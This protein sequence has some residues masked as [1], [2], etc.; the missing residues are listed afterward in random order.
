MFICRN[1]DARNM[2]GVVY[3]RCQQHSQR[4]KHATQSFV[5]VAIDE[6]IY[7]R[8]YLGKSEP[9]GLVSCCRYRV[10]QHKA[11]VSRV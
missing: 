9:T 3:L 2:K 8:E 5:R 1:V 6:V 7:A 11:E 4:I 10:S